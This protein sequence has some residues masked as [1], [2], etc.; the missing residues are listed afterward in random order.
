MNATHLVTAYPQRDLLRITLGGFFGPA[1]VASFN[2][3]RMAAHAQL[4][5]ARNQHVTLVDVSDMRLQP[6]DVVALFRG[7]IA[8]P[9]TRSRKLA[10]VTGCSVVRM[11]VRRLIERQGIAVFTHAADAEAWLTRSDAAWPLAG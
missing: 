9:A 2:R 3:A 6:Q 5:C 4:T 7:I 11:Q 10:L 1:D 8:D